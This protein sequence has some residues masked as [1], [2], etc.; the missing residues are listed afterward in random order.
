MITNHDSQGLVA[1][2]AR[3]TKSELRSRV[4]T[5]TTMAGDQ[6]L[7]SYLTIRAIQ[8]YS[9]A[10]ELLIDSNA[11]SRSIAAMHEK[12]GGAYTQR[13]NLDEAWQE[14]R[15]ALQLVTVEPQ[16]ESDHLLHLYNHLSELGTRWLGFFN[17]NPSLQ[18]IR[19]YIDAGLKLLE[20]KPISGQN[21]E[22]LTY[23]AF[24][25]VR[26][27]LESTN[28]QERARFAD[29]ALQSGNEALRIAEELND[30]GAIWLTLD[31]LAYVY[32]KQHKYQDAHKIEHYREKF[33]DKVKS[34]VELNDLYYS[35]GWA[36]EAVND[37]PTALK[38]FG[39]SWRVAQ[40]MESPSMLLSC[41]IGRMLAW[42]RWNRWDEA[43]QAAKSILQMV[44]QYQLNEPWQLE[45]LETLA[46]IAYATGQEEE[47]DSYLRQYKRILERYCTAAD[48]AP[49]MPLIHL[50]RE[51]WT[52]AAAEYREL[53]ER[54][55]PFPSPNMLALLAELVVITGE[56]IEVQQAS[57]AKAISATEQSGTR[58][59]LA[60]A[61]RARGR[62]H[63]EQHHWKQAEADLKQSL[64]W[65]E[66][67]DLPWDRGKAFYCLGLLYRRRADVR[68]KNRPD[69]RKAD[70][71]R[72]QFHFEKALGFFESLNAVHDVERAR[73]A[74]AQDHRVPV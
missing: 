13:G 42:Q 50:V 20:G 26:N 66:D 4:I 22:F 35:L 37:Y 14:Y 70:L 74:L 23:Q 17:T 71:G 9:E 24:W 69:E 8:A 6:A 53:L 62:M 33:A 49:T 59:S 38:W 34:R 44:E 51:D 32:T 18:D 57:C 43:Q 58:R 61:L 72:A 7:H 46:I 25:Y 1:S 30:T 16:E 31:A 28:T 39:Y 63:L 55:E 68:G 10:L 40:S 73:L 67:L 48:T 2:A 41:L 47:G 21:A 12:L 52:R 54:S 36:H 3:L 19:T 56:S 65:V 45:A 11:D 27:Q 29:L 60:I 15:R 64:K 5:Y